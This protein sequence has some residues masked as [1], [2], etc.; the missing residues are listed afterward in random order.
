MLTV[1]Q[2]STGENWN[3]IMF[4][5]MRNEAD[6]I[7]GKNCGKWYSPIYF[8]SFNCICSIVMLNLFVLVIL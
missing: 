6:C 3:S 2:C 7:P 4:D 8:I 1:I 5:Y